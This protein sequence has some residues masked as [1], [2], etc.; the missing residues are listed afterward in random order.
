VPRLLGRAEHQ[1]GNSGSQPFHTIN[2]TAAAQV[3]LS[4]QVLLRIQIR[5]ATPNRD[6]TLCQGLF[7]FTF[8]IL[9]AVGKVLPVAGLLSEFRASGDPS[10]APATR[11]CSFADAHQRAANP[12]LRH[13]HHRLI[14]QA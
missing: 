2:G 14:T 5:L 13:P 1:N 7:G 3:R 11:K 4:I 10:V 6:Q 9:L 12:W 8:R